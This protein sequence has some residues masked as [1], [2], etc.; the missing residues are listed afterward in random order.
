MVNVGL[1]VLWMVNPVTAEAGFSVQVRSI[2]AGPKKGTGTGAR[3]VRF[4]GAEGTDQ[5]T[6]IEAMFDQAH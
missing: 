1:V 6:W 4:P 2:V 3:A 5:G